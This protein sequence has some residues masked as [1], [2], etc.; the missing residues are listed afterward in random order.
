MSH[1]GDSLMAASHANERP[2][3]TALQLPSLMVG[4]AVF[5]HHYNQDVSKVPTQNILSRAIEAG[6]NGRA[7]III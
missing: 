6:A 7:F 4:G 1:E 5:S 2:P 3:Q